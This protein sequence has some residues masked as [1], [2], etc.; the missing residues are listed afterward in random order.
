MSA[1]RLT[2]TPDLREVSTQLGVFPF[3]ILHWWLN[4]PVLT[5][6]IALAAMLF[7]P[8]DLKSLPIDRI[9]F[10]AMIVL[11]CL[12]LLLRCDTL[13]T[14][15]AT[16][17]LL[18]LLFLGLLSAFTQPYDP[19][20][21]SVFVAKYAVPF[22]C[23]HIAGM[24][25]RDEVSRRRLEY[26]L[27]TAL[28]YLS[29]ISIFSLLNAS[30]LIVPRFITDPGI[31]IHA[32][33]ARGPFLQAVA[34][35]VCL[36]L[37]GLLA[38]D[39]FRRRHLNRAVGVFLFFAVPVALLATK[40][41]AVWLAA[42]LAVL[43]LLWFGS[44]LRVRR[45]ALAL[46]IAA[47]VL[48]GT[49]RIYQTQTDSLAERLLDR[50]PVDFRTEMYSAGWQMFTEKPL[51]GWGTEWDIQPEVEKRVSSFRPEYYVFHNTFLE[52]AVE[53]GLL[54]VGLYAWLMMCLL[55]LHNSNPD[56]READGPFAGPYFRT[57]WPLLL[58]VYL[59]NASAVVM[60]Y[61]FVNALI[62]TIAG[63][64]A[65]NSKGVAIAETF[66]PGGVAA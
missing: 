50:S 26:F 43:L 61:Q 48:G 8:P 53:R 60:N 24:V 16:W 13:R 15:S 52:L 35:G 57:L 4:L 39:S 49:L 62:F 47:A 12:R 22:V 59:I 30:S 19:Q 58:L 34:N 32:D 17:P 25:F 41:R 42:V 14:Y 31:G 44:A 21:W 20:V 18:A 40:T 10:L 45:V 2:T 28:I 36:A 23:F 27:L 51:L 46:C 54:G 1:A 65:A 33:R 66:S 55:R 7:R 38:L 5:F 3:R 6:L 11:V 29:V 56:L 37:L 9:A 63:I 64:L